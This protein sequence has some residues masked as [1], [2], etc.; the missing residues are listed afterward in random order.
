MQDSG[1]RTEAVEPL[2]PR[3]IELLMLLS[4]GHTT[5]SISRLLKLSENTVKAYKKYLYAKLEVSTAAEA[6]AR[7]LRE[8]MIE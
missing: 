7:A 3:E 2:S 1:V 5:P 8:G 6:V 4:N